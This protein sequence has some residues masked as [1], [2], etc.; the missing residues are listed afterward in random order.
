MK[1]FY[2]VSGRIP[3]DDEDTI[4]VVQAE[5]I[6]DATDEFTDAML[7]ENEPTEYGEEGEPV[8]YVNYV[9]RCGTVEPTI[10]WVNY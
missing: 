7:K 9:I 1:V 8:V 6:D 4:K 5:D 3:Y 10:E 2:I